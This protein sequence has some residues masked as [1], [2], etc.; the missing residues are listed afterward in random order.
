ATNA[1]KPGLQRSGQAADGGITGHDL[2]QRSCGFKLAGGLPDLVQRKKQQTVLLE[3]LAG[4]ERLDRREIRRVAL[5]LLFERSGRGVREFRRRGLD[6][7]KDGVVP[8]ERL[9]ELL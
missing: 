2:D 4:A 5:Q 6:D 9:F 7:G 3:E 1:G 8:I